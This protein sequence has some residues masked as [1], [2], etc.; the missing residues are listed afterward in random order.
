MSAQTR[1][2]IGL[3]LLLYPIVVVLGALVVS[4][5][6]TSP[7]ADRESFVREMYRAGYAHAALVLVLALTVLHYVD[8]A[9]L[10][11]TAKRFVRW[12]I[13]I[14]ALFLAIGFGLAAASGGRMDP[15][16][17]MAVVMLGSAFLISGLVV[18]G[19]GL[20]RR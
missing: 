17:A 1:R 8:D 13:P 7:Y 18:L 4:S 12:S 15:A 14:A 6:L 9:L 16:I 11:N 19:I 20:M 3:L 2:T 10:N 5:G